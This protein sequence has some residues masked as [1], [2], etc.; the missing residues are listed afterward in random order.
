MRF[1]CCNAI[2]S[3]FSVSCRS[4]SLPLCIFYKEKRVSPVTGRSKA[5]TRGRSRSPA[6]THLSVG[7]E[8]A[9]DLDLVERVPGEMDVP[10]RAG[11]EPGVEIDLELADGADPLLSAGVLLNL[12]P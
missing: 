9:R 7:D 11:P 5:K 3:S 6:C 8:L 12:G 4:R 10:K 2:P 1:G